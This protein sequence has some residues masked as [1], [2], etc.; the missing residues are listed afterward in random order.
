MKNK[1][2]SAIRHINNIL[3]FLSLSFIQT[4]NG[5]LVSFG[6]ILLYLIFN[7]LINMLSGYVKIDTNRIFIFIAWSFFV[8][9]LIKFNQDINIEVYIELFWLIM[10]TCILGISI[11]IY[12]IDSKKILTTFVISSGVLGLASIICYFLKIE[13]SGIIAHPYAGTRLVGGFDGPNEAAAFYLIACTY[14]F[15]RFIKDKS[16]IYL[17]HSM[18]MILV[19][20]LTWS[21]GGIFGLIIMGIISIL[22]LYR[23]KLYK[24][25]SLKNIIVLITLFIIIK[26][27][28]MP[29]FIFVRRNST[30]R[31]DMVFTSL[32]PFFER[33][34]LGWGLGNFSEI[35]G[36]GNATPHNEFIFILF[37][38]GLYGLFLFSIFIILIFLRAKNKKMYIELILIFSFF[39]QEMTFNHLIRG[40]V[41]LIFWLLVALIVSSG[42]KEVNDSDKQLIEGN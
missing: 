30:G 18:I 32:Q 22:Y 4:T 14:S 9:S 40:R 19:V 31:L 26:Y 24:L 3:L 23:G 35:S 42:N 15:N 34:L 29:Q 16:K 41:N 39:T 2:L 12:K 28:V 6:L 8:L 21:R 10:G 37:S 36:L 38:S 27:F 13:I 11:F 17:I 33:P 20:V 5:Q 1:R 25:F 7:L